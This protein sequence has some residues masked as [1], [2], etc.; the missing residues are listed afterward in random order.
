MKRALHRRNSFLLFVVVA[1]MLLMTAC[2]NT[3]A[4]PVP[5]ATTVQSVAPTATTVQSTGNPTAAAT[6]VTSGG[7]RRAPVGSVTNIERSEPKGELSSH[8]L[9][10]SNRDAALNSLEAR[11]TPTPQAEAT[12]TEEV[13]TQN[14]NAPEDWVVIL[15]SDFSTEDTGSWM[16][17]EED[18]FSSTL[19]DGRLVQT[20]EDGTGFFNWA[21]ETDNW[22]D[23]YISA[24]IELDGDGFGGLTA[25]LSREDGNWFDIICGISTAGTYG[26]YKEV[27]SQNEKMAGGRSSAIKKTG[28]NELA[29]LGVGDEFTF[30]INGK[31]VKQFSGEGLVEGTWGTYVE[32]PQGTTTNM[33]IDRVLFMGPGEEPID[34]PTPTAEPDDPTEEPAPTDEPTEEPVDEPTATATTIVEENV[35][36][37]TDFSE[38]EG[39]WATGEGDTYSVRVEDGKL[40]VAALAAGNVVGTI[41]TEA[42]EL[43]D[44]RI[45]ATFLVEDTSS[46][47]QPGFVG[48]SARSQEFL[49]DFEDWAQVFCGI[50]NLGD[51]SCYR[52]STGSDGSLNFKQIMG[53]NT[54][55]IKADKENTIALTSNGSRWT[56]EI[57]GSKVGSFSDNSQKEG[58]WGVLVLSGDDTTTGYFSQINVYDR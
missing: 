19:E 39:T 58:G 53:G 14:G 25:K 38:D 47:D 2:D 10:V 52:V 6:P 35:I 18:G 15:E 26:C 48:V 5:T 41:P 51:Y 4:T 31:Q 54:S 23:G 29:L 33:A 12:P 50:N 56:F 8:T 44:A 7:I 32:S 9:E 13:A 37:S 20:A 24:T 22:T 3:P 21:D 55:K 45:E 36:V 16:V 46:E 27:D 34:E 57:N 43:A 1:S 30:Y 28:I 40:V 42:G 49:S 17:G 11:N